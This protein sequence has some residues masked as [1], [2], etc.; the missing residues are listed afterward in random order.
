M[1]GDALMATIN[2]ADIVNDPD[3]ASYLPGA[4][5]R[6]T[7]SFVL[8]KWKSITTT[9]DF[10]GVVQPS[11]AKELKMVPEGDRVTGAMSFHSS[12]VIYETHAGDTNSP[13]GISDV[14]TWHNQPYRVIY[15]AP[16]DTFGYWL[17]IA[18]RMSGK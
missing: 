8:G 13:D 2:M 7:G 15:V 5:A 10:Y 11:T 4:I 1:G 14:I 18:V 17:A 9:L 3:F 12:S 16:W 6:D